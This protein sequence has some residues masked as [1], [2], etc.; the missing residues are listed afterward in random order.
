MEDAEDT[1]Q[2]EINGR[3]LTLSDTSTSASISSPSKITEKQDWKILHNYPLRQLP[4][5]QPEKNALD[6]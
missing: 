4:K 1:L 3:S 2:E 5:G 6:K